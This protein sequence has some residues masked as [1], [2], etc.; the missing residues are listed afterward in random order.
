MSSLIWR[1]SLSLLTAKWRWC[2]GGGVWRSVDQT[3]GVDEMCARAGGEIRWEKER[4][5]ETIAAGLV[6]DF[7]YA[8][9]FCCCTCAWASHLSTAAAAGA[10]F[11]W[12]LTFL[13]MRVVT[14]YSVGLLFSACS[15]W[16]LPVLLSKMPVCVFLAINGLFLLAISLLFELP[17][18]AFA[19]D[20]FFL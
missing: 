7:F 20:F 15:L 1:L 17:L 9:S 11:L 3:E 13:A 6:V 16:N 14:A 2:A 12:W 18:S 5:R 19:S 10:P 4:E 8:H